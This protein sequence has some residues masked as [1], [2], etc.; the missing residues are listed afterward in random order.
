MLAT[1]D[2]LEAAPTYCAAVFFG[3][4]LDLVNS[5]TPGAIDGQGTMTFVRLGERYLGVTNEHVLSEAPDKHGDRVFHLALKRHTPFP[6]RLVARTTF[7]NPA[8]PYDLAVFDVPKDEIESNGKRFALVEESCRLVEGE[9]AL[10]VGFP[11]ERRRVEGP[12][13]AHPTYVVVSTCRSLSDRK[14]ILHDVLPNECRH[15]DFGGMSG[16]PIFRLASE[17]LELAGLI[18]QG[19]FRSDD[20]DWQAPELWIWGFPLTVATLEQAIEYGT[21][22]KRKSS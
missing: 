1:N 14:I 13:M 12:I 21:S 17:N 15:F 10:A 9:M 19:E 16:G 3:R 2:A 22:R 20:K 5:G 8:A 6:L 4:F 7:D 11:G 18:F